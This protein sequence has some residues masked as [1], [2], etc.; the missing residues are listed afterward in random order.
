MATR[1]ARRGGPASTLRAT[2]DRPLQVVTPGTVDYRRAWDWQRRLARARAADEVGDV[3]LLLQHPPTYT[4]GT[5][6]DRANVLLDEAG[7]ADAGIDLVQIDRGGDVTYHGP[8]QLVGYPILRLDGPRVVDYVR[9]LEELNLRL[10][11]AHGVDAY[12]IDDLTGVW[13]DAGKVTAIGVRVT[14]GR[15]TQHGW[16][17][18]VT[19]DLDEFRG[20]VPCGIDDRPVT[21]M[22]ALGADLDMATAVDDTVAAF[23]EVF[24]AALEPVAADGLGPGLGP[25]GSSGTD[26]VVP[27]ATGSA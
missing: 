20:I 7:L 18:N 25:D 24:G 21:S 12:R 22:A 6:A 4:L 1:S 14:A 26:A 13:T 2:P 17:T 23:G 11:A 9:A 3:L 8:G 16:A 15:V 19:T 5:R 10:L 27:A